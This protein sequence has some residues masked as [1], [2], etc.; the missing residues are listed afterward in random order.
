MPLLKFI[1]GNSVI[2]DKNIDYKVD[3][4][5]DIY[6]NINS[7]LEALFNKNN[8]NYEKI[9]EDNE[10]NKL[11][12]K[13]DGKKEFRGIYCYESTNLQKNVLQI[14]K[15]L[16]NSIPNAKNILFCNK[17][18]AIEEL[19]AFLY[20]ALLCSSNS[21]YIIAGIELLPFKEQITFQSILKELYINKEK[22][23]K[24]CLVIVYMNKDADIVKYLKNIRQSSFEDLLKNL[25]N[26]NVDGVAHNIQLI[27]SDVSGLGKS[28]YIKS[29][30][31]EI[32]KEYIHFPLGGVF[33][34]KDVLKRLKKLNENINIKNSIIHLDL[35][36][37]EQIDLM[38]EF[39]FSLLITRIYGQNDDI[40]YLP[41]NIPLKSKYQM[42][43]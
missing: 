19:T 10:N 4:E 33:T 30:I 8:I 38:M 35:Y 20:R 17:E 23:M 9:K 27:T 41:E 42:G 36:D 2:E 25:D 14:Y 16:K 13:D 43:L 24:S 3:N 12:K 39:F 1:S 26:I 15:I 11:K 37:T 40:L 18:T 6:F 31:K 32:N 29:K 21:C 22:Q 5:K 34:R 7:Y 28:T